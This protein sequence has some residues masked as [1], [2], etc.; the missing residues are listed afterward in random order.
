MDAYYIYMKNGRMKYKSK[1]F[2]LSV[3]SAFVQFR[4]GC[5]NIIRKHFKKYGIAYINLG[6]EEM[7]NYKMVING[8]KKYK[9][10]G[11]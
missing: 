4:Y 10:V 11:F 6:F 1:N 3:Y 8:V 2:T 5:C 7:V 9:N